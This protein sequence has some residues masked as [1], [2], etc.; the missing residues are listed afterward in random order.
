MELQQFDIVEDRKL[1]RL[2]ILWDMMDQVERRDTLNYLTERLAS[3]KNSTAY[4]KNVHVHIPSV[5]KSISAIQ[6]IDDFD[7]SSY[8][9][10]SS[11]MQ[12]KGTRFTV[13][14]DALNLSAVRLTGT[15]GEPRFLSFRWSWIHTIFR[16][17]S[18]GLIC[19]LR[20]QRF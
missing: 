20:V 9:Y 17:N 16:M 19:T 13:K 8:L 12:G 1:N 18:H 4:I 11:G 15:R 3:F 10:F 5:G 2:A 14:E 7:K 6:G